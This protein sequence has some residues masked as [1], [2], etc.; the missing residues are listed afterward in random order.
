VHVKV[1][2]NWDERIMAKWAAKQMV[3]EMKK[4]LKERQSS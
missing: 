1:L 3:N 2:P 4:A